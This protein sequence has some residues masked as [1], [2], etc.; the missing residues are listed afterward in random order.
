[1][2]VPTSLLLSQSL[3]TKLFVLLPLK[4]NFFS[5]PYMCSMGN[6]SYHSVTIFPPLSPPCCGI[7][8]L[9]LPAPPSPLAH[10]VVFWHVKSTTIVTIEDHCQVEEEVGKGVILDSIPLCFHHSLG[11]SDGEVS[12]SPL[13]NR[14]LKIVSQSDVLKGTINLLPSWTC[15]FFVK[16]RHLPLSRHVCSCCLHVECSQ[17]DS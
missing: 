4:Q 6:L 16:I 8:H 7:F 13:K 11:S 10:F 1:M 5:F 9:G 12:S 15:S 17:K 14:K 3:V 2:W